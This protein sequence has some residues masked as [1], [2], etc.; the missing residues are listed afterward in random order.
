M[1]AMM[2]RFVNKVQLAFPCVFSLKSSG[3]VH[4]ATRGP[5]HWKIINFIHTK[6]ALVVLAMVIKH[7]TVANPVLGTRRVPFGPCV[8]AFSWIVLKPIQFG[9][10]KTKRRTFLAALNVLFWSYVLLKCWF[11]EWVLQFFC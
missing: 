2:L 5:H 10:K 7:A 3:N 8:Q 9:N 11:W 6:N 4:G 1:R